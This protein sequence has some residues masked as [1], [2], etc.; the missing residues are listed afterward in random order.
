MANLTAFT[1]AMTGIASQHLEQN[2][3]PEAGAVNL[4]EF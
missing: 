2:R 4:F 1:A 3:A